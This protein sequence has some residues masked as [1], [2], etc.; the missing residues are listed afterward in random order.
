MHRSIDWCVAAVGATAA[1]E[2]GDGSAMVAGSRCALRV[3]KK[4]PFV[5]LGNK[6]LNIFHRS[7]C[8]SIFLLCM[9]YIEVTKRSM[10]DRTRKLWQTY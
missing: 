9:A 8:D 7:F 1:V 4:L 6:E 2:N 3:K 10:Y 5:A